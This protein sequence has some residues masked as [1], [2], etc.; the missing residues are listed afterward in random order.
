MAKSKKK[1]SNTVKANFKDVKVFKTPP[2]GDYVLKVIEAEL[3]ESSNNNNAVISLECE[4]A[5]GKY[6]GSKV[7]HTLVFS[8]KALWKTREA[9]EAM[10]QDVPDGEMEIDPSDLV[11]CEF[12]ATLF[13]DTYEG[14]KRAKIAEFLAAD[15]VSEDEGDEEE[16]EDNEEEEEDTKKS[17]KK[18][19]K[20]KK[21]D[22]DEEEDDVDVNS[23][24]EDELQ[25]LIDDKGL[26]VDLDDYSSIKKKRK[27]VAEALEGGDNEEE[28]E[29]SEETT[30]TE[31]QIN[32][33]GSEEL[34]ALNDDLE[35]E[36]EDID[37][38]S[39]KT[40][41]RNVIKALKKKGLL[42]E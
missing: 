7:W 37:E 5:Q 24:D 27:A 4:V 33:M 36:I 1:K 19:S 42:E 30:Y 20:S 23:L 25:E 10:G 8:E 14:T 9:L 41:R 13:H 28:D 35:L 3:G 31:D 18:K 29:D 11:D 39:K 12:G 2:E 38:M 26:D 40:A 21:K 16:E 32:D 34:E 22:E 17:S 6:E 15:E